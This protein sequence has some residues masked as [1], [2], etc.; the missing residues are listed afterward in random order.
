MGEL[1]RMPA[2]RRFHSKSRTGCARCKTR[3]VKCDEKKP[4]CSNCVRQGAE[5]VY[6]NASPTASAT[7]KP[8][9]PYQPLNGE[10]VQN[11]YDGFDLLLM[12]HF[13]SSTALELFPSEGARHVWQHILPQEAS[14]SPLLMHGILALAGL[15]VACGDAASPMASQARTRALHHQQ[16]GLAL[17]QATLQDPAKA[18]IYATFAFSIMLVIL[19]FASAQAEPTFPSVDGILELFGLFRGVGVIGAHIAVHY[20]WMLTI[21][22]RIGHW[23]R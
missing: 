15:D 16:R 9:T 18:D 20:Q 17:F 13:S 4:T 7:D 21:R 23:L 22:H 1:R 6:S 8:E 11:Q 19:A 3:R 14:R 2:S 5:C 10:G 12:N